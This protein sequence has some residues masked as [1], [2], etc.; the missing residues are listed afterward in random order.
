MAALALVLAGGDAA[1]EAAACCRWQ[2]AE[3][4]PPFS[5]RELEQAV[6]IRRAPGDGSG[7]AV[8][9]AW[10]RPGLVEA[11]TRLRRRVVA[12]GE[13]RGP[14][15]ARLVAIA[16]LDVMRPLPVGEVASNEPAIAAVTPE[17]NTVPGRL[18]LGLAGAVNHGATSA[19]F[20]L[21]P[22]AAA[23]WRLARG[24]A[25]ELGLRLELGYG[26]ARGQVGAPIGGE[27]AV[28]AV[29]LVPVRLGIEGARGA[30]AASAGVMARPYFARGWG[31]GNGA[32]AGGYL[33]AE[34][35]WPADRALAGVLGVGVDLAANAVD[36]RVGGRSLLA[37]GRVVPWARLG[38]GWRAL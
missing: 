38:L 2:F 13:A 32:I 36:F 10:A 37:T 31:G 26:Q 8:T 1:A 21:E 20:A 33:G 30:F 3:A 5:A 11:R 15:A 24:D 9:V 35:R 14:E 22:V 34:V 28:F 18:R 7:E 27:S 25:G 29:H 23:A 17:A 16:V 19:G 12:L 4:L 6:Q